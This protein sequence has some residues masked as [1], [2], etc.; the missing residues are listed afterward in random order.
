MTDQLFAV[1][2]GQEGE[3]LVSEAL[4]LAREGDLLALAESPIARCDL[5]GCWYVGAEPHGSDDRGRAAQAML[6]WLIERLKPGGAHSWTALSW[7]PYNVLSAFYSEGRR[8]AEIAELMGVAE[9]TIYP[10]RSQAIAALTKILRE[11]L[12]RPADLRPNYAIEALYPSLPPAQQALLR[13]SALIDGPLS[14]ALLHDLARSVNI[15]GIEPHLQALSAAGILETDQQ[16]TAYALQPKLR[17]FLLTLVTPAERETLHAIAGQYAAQAGEYLAAARHWRL[18][19]TFALAAQLLIYHHQAIIAA[20]Q[21]DQLRALL[22]EFRPSELADSSQ[23]ARLKI[24]SGDV[25]MTMNDVPT[26]LREYQQALNADDV[27]T[28]AEAYYRRGKAFRSQNT[29]EAQAHFAYAIGLL[30]G[31]EVNAPLLSK[32][33][34]DQ[35][36]MFFQDRQDWAQAE[37]SLR[38]AAALVSPSNRAAWAEVANAW[39]MFYAHQ[40]QHQQAIVHHQSAWLAANEVQ[41]TTMQAHTAHNLGNDYMFLRQYDQALAYFEESAGLARQTGNRSMEGLSQKSI[42]ACRFWLGDFAGAI[43]HYQA[44]RAIFAAM[45][46][47]NW[48]ANTCYDLAEAYAELGDVPHMQRY[49]AEAVAL[50]R[51]AGL[52]RLLH[53]LHSLTRTYPGLYP[54][55]AELNERQQRAYDYL[56]QHQAISNREYRDLTA[57]SPKQAARDLNELLDLGIITRVGEGRSTEY[58]LVEE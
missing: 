29:A 8:I 4:R 27:L 18:G 23:W 11:E 52:D 31:A 16:R 43:E 58:R 49:F 42:G 7:R 33:Y 15:G 44:A 28:K 47:R 21:G 55:A 46:N 17:S 56:K 38:R 57:V 22:A 37:N 34:L 50:A 10:I 12:T 30:E 20:Q 45:H 6:V 1:L 54:P 41:D 14:L 24:I 53:D 13:A 2:E 39:G 48:Q 19:G 32:A 35:A 26:A 51:E 25:A 5:V 3:K 36:W 40:G 9:Q